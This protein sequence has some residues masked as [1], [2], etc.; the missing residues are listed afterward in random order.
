ML[1]L[2][3]I[4]A[5][6]SMTLSECA[7]AA[8]RR[9]STE[10]EF[11]ALEKASGG[12]LGACLY[13]T[14]SGMQIGYRANERFPMCSTFKSVLA[15]A[16]LARSTRDEGLLQRPVKY[17]RS[18]LVGYS[19]ISGKH[20]EDGMTVADLCDAV[21]RYS[22]NTAANLLIRMLGG[23]AA[24]TAF[25][26]SIGDGS[27]RL[28]RYE[29]ELNT[30]IPGDVR[31]TSTPAAMGQTLRALVLGDALPPYQRTLL[32][33]WLRESTT[34]AHRIRAGVPAGWSVG[35]K[36]GSGDH[37]TSND[38]AILWPPGRAPLSL[39]VFYTQVERDAKWK[40]EV[41]AAAARIAVNALR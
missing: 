34:G 7:G 19:P 29:T 22:D 21:T 38:A 27:F 32:T 41:I 39:V 4:A 10:A 37:G 30:A 15:G 6:F 20:V 26:R 40:D 16:V 17:S 36:T 24:V 18:D 11:A 3:A 9:A 33:R 12:R 2:S 35:D 13:D 14:A 5:P 23:P 25:A 8:T 28:D 31:D 1:L